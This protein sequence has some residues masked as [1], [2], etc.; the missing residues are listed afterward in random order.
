[1]L[2][3]KPRILEYLASSSPDGLTRGTL[4]NYLQLQPI[5]HVAPNGKTA[6]GRWRFLAELGEWQ[7]SQSWGSGVY[8]NE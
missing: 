6:Q 3:G 8:E 7:K 4:M 1:V 5:V 2:L